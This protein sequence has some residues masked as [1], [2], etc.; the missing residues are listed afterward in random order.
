M[1]QVSYRK[2][3]FERL[4]IDPGLDKTLHQISA[5][6]RFS[7]PNPT[8]NEM[9]LKAPL[10]CQHRAILKCAISLFVKHMRSSC[11][12]SFTSAISPELREF[13][14]LQYWFPSSKNSQPCVVS[15]LRRSKSNHLPA[16]PAQKRAQ[17]ACNSMNT[18]IPVAGV[19]NS[20][21]L[22]LTISRIASKKLRG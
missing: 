22:A 8:M 13:S 1:S 15:I 12:L 16:G 7:R 5:T 11:H 20:F 3:P 19:L 4:S 21:L 9:A 18:P 10:S 6:R 2:Q 14:S 17:S